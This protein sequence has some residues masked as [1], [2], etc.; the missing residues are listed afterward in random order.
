MLVPS[1]RGL[2]SEK[3]WTLEP[4]RGAPGAKTSQTPG[5]SL[6][7]GSLIPQGRGT[8][9]QEEGGGEQ[10]KSGYMTAGWRPTGL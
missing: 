5:A 4:A 1:L 10:R 6:S 9:T 8:L 7:A 3:R 2:V